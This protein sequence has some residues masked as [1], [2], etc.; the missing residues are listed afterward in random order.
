MNSAAFIRITDAFTEIGSVYADR[1]AR[2]G[3]DVVLVACNCVRKER[4]TNVED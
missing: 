3:H 1:F 4:A 2:R